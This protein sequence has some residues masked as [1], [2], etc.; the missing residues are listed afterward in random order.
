MTDKEKIREIKNWLKGEIEEAD[1][2]RMKAQKEVLPS[3]GMREVII[4]VVHKKVL[5]KI[6]EIEKAD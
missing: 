2:R 1:K 3:K 5:N 4:W 6:E